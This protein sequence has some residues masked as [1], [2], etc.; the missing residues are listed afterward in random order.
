MTR[1]QPCRQNSRRTPKPSFVGMMFTSP[2]PLG[3]TTRRRRSRSAT[4]NGSTPSGR[5]RV[6]IHLFQFG[7][8]KLSFEEKCCESSAPTA[9]S[10]TLLR[11]SIASGGTSSER[12]ESTRAGLASAL[13]RLISIEA[14]GPWQAR[15]CPCS[16][17]CSTRRRI[18]RSVGRSPAT[19]SAARL[20]KRPASS[21][22]IA[23][24]EAS[25]HRWKEVPARSSS[26][27]SQRSPWSRCPS[28]RGRGVHS[29]IASAKNAPKE[30]C[31][32]SVSLATLPAGERSSTRWL[33]LRTPR[34]LR[35]R[36]MEPRS[37][38]V[39]VAHDR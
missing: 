16:R 8:L 19:T 25:T 7:G 10:R 39:A 35:T 22:G 17:S 36:A 5:K 29:P 14:G 18:Q 2:R 33:N 34:T 28:T 6:G 13:I 12:Q 23:R 3:P 11:S 37:D 4:S 30:A 31:S 9:R 1:P 32:I 24:F 20:L 27:Q 21:S 26:K 15:A 38:F